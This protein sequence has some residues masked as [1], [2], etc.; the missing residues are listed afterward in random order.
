MKGRTVA[1]RYVGER[2]NRL[3]G[4]AGA[5]SRAR[6]AVD[7]LAWVHPATSE[8]EF[9]NAYELLVATI[10]SAQTTDR[11]VNQVTRGLFARYP[12]PAA[13]AIAHLSDLEADLHAI[14][15]FRAKARTILAAGR[16]LVEHHGGKVPASMS[17]LLSVPGVGRKSANA[18]LVVAFGVPGIVTDRHVIRVAQRLELVTDGRPEHVERR[19]RRLLPSRDWGP[20]SLRMTRHGRYVCVARRPHCEACVL[21]DFCPSSTTRSWPREERLELSL[22]LRSSQT[23]R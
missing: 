8:L 3:S 5:K 12:D 6:Q 17:Q 10:L 19:L 20:F 16:D 23:G 15:F 13:L 2:E 9:A 1:Q 7:R 4:P 21:N 11:G 22:S 14:G 18:I